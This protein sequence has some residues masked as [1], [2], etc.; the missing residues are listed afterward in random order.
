[1]NGRARESQAPPGGAEKSSHLA[2]TWTGSSTDNWSLQI[3]DNWEEKEASEKGPSYFEAADGTQGL[4]IST[5]SR[6]P[7]QEII[8][9]IEM[10]S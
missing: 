8:D 2:V 4:Y 5:W 10:R 7:L 1:V 6:E 3:P 9:S